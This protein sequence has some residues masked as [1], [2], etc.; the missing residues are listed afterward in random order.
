MTFWKVEVSFRRQALSADVCGFFCGYFQRV[1]TRFRWGERWGWAV[2]MLVVSL[3]A[4]PI[5]YD[6]RWWQPGLPDPGGFSR[7]GEG[8]EPGAALLK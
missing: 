7:G 8:L 5:H 4:V 2:Q 1:G 3:L 6:R